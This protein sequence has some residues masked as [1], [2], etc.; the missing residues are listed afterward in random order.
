MMETAGEVRVSSDEKPLALKAQN[1]STF[2]I[3]SID[4]YRALD[5]GLLNDRMHHVI[6]FPSPSPSLWQ[7]EDQPS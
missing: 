6:H 3:V 2:L 1:P 5:P 4:P 7:L